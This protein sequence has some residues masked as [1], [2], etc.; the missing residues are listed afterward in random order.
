MIGLLLSGLILTG[1]MRA[2]P[3]EE[4]IALKNSVEILKLS[5]SEQSMLK[6]AVRQNLK[7]PDSAKF[8]SYTAFSFI[9]KGDKQIAVCGYVN[10]KNSYGGYGGEQAYIALK[11]G[12][13]FA[14]AGPGKFYG[15]VCNDSYG[16]VP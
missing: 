10:A 9:E 4:E 11:A 6:Q 13:D 3:N 8:G 1:C 16:I 14:V 7:D 15:V 12:S 2:G 5:K